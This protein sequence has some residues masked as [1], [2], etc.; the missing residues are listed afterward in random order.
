MT[1]PPPPQLVIFRTRSPPDGNGD[2][3]PSSSSPEKMKADA[4]VD[5]AVDAS[6]RDLHD[7]AAAALGVARAALRLSIGGEESTL[8]ELYIPGE[9]RAEQPIITFVLTLKF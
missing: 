9:T 6:L 4:N 8:S 7:A 2:P 5:V 3:D 1:P